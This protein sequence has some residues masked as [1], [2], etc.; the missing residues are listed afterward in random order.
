MT[1][2]RENST[3]TDSPPASALAEGNGDN[4]ELDELVKRAVEKL[5]QSIKKRLADMETNG[6]QVDESKPRS[7]YYWLFTVE[8]SL[9]YSLCESC[10]KIYLKDE[11]KVTE[12]DNGYVMLNIMMCPDCAK[13]NIEVKQAWKHGFS[14]K[15]VEGNAGGYGDGYG[16]GGGGGWNRNGGGRSGYGGGGGGRGGYGGGGW[17]DMM[18][19]RD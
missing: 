15:W 10:T 4:G 7:P 1:K 11:E 19:R 14:K 6:G 13:S 3:S 17:A 2:Q 12:L 18:S 16:R 8:R 5:V 9:R